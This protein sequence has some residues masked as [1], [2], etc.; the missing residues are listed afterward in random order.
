M[1]QETTN[2]RLGEA[3][4]HHGHEEEQPVNQAF[5]VL[6]VEELAQ[7]RQ[8]GGRG[9]LGAQ[10]DQRL[11]RDTTNT[12]LGL[13]QAHQQRHGLRGR[14]TTRALMTRRGNSKS[15]RVVPACKG[16]AYSTPSPLTDEAKPS[17]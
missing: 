4:V 14:S 2:F 16:H 3:V 13:G 6:A 17:A 9:R 11:H 10:V 5:L 1:T 7:Q 8:Q 12:N 15:A